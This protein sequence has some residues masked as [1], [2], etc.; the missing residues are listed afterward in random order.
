MRAPGKHQKITAATVGL[1]LLGL[2]HACQH[3]RPGAIPAP[4]EAYLRFA[5][6]ACDVVESNVP[7]ITRIA[8]TVAQRHL[9]GGVIGFPWNA[10]GLQQELMGR[11]GGLVHIGFE[12]PF[13]SA[14]T[15][16]EKTNDIAIIGWDRAPGP[17]DLQALRDAKARGCYV[18]GFGPRKMQALAPHLALCDVWIDSAFGE[19]D[20]VVGFADGSMGGHGNCLMNTLN[21][22]VLTAEIVAALTRQGRMPTMWKSY[23]Y[24]D[25]RDWGERYL[26]KK[27]FHDEFQIA[28]LAAGNL[29]KEYLEQI[30]VHLRK[31]ENSQLPEVTRTAT[32]IAREVSQ[33]RRLTVVTMGHMPWT[34]VGKY[35]DDR[36]ASPLELNHGDPAAV[37]NYLT[38]TQQGALIL[39]LGYSGQHQ[40]ETAI[41]EKKHQRE[42]LITAADNPRPEW[43]LPTNLVSKIEMG[44]EFGDACVTIPGYPIKVF[45][46][47][48]IMQLVA[49]ECVNVEVLDRIARGNRTT[50]TAPLKNIR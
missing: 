15:E 33:G 25:G 4:S 48:G 2:L 21:G 42:M 23:S 9:D 26:G 34:F 35:E 27:L 10:Q 18:I 49:Y 28:P 7:M 14:R 36:W 43:Q 41:F 30:R 47:S 45:P 46:P 12:R 6:S 20:R 29:A 44:W 22:W 16:A 1:L 39:R 11:S 5:L 50:R 3:T 40:D 32:L 31:F 24:A 37:T 17:A 38:H 19:D 8:E 13:K